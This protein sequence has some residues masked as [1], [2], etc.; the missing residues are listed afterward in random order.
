MRHAKIFL[1][2]YE[3]FHILPPTVFESQK[4]DGCEVIKCNSLNTYTRIYVIHHLMSLQK[5]VNERERRLISTNH[6]VYGISNQCF[7]THI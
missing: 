2:L 7:Q 5:A 3:C 6:I 1:Y 4:K